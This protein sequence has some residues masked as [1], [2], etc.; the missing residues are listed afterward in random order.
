MS[1]EIA[2]QVAKRYRIAGRFAEGMAKGKLTADPAYRE[3]LSLLGDEGTLVDIGCGEG[4]LLA[5]T[6]AL[7]PRITLVGLDIDT[8]RLDLARAVLVDESNIEILEGDI[9]TAPIPD[10]DVITVLDVLHYLPVEMQDDALSRL[11]GALKPGGTLLIRDADASQGLRSTIT[12]ISERVA[13]VIGRHKG[14]GVYM[15]PADDT[16]AVL[17]S[18]GL[19]VEVKPCSE[20]T[21]FANVLIVARLPV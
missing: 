16:C 7:K 18:A 9:R 11:A 14:I 6:R 15:R 13:V 8:R 19:S 17:R 21:P 5:Y 4:L 3:V 1:R 20:G 2:K 12:E 10:A